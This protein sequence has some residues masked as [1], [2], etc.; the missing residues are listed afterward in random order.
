[1]FTKTILATAAA[2]LISAGAMAVSTSAAD[3]HYSLKVSGGYYVTKYVY[4]PKTI[5]NTYYQTVL[6][7]YDYWNHPIYKQIPYQ[8]C[9]TVSL[10]V[11]Q[12]VFVPYASYSSN[13]GL[14]LHLSY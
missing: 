8:A 10:K 13:Y 1:M 2:A 5:C 6:A 9:K 3:A 12:Q 14:S 7:G 11:K 4:V